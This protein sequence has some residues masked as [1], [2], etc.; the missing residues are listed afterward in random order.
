MKERLWCVTVYVQNKNKDFLLLHHKRLNQWV[1]P[2]GK[3][4]EGEIP[5]EAALRECLEETGLEIQLIGQSLPFVSSSSLVQ[6]LICPFGIQLNAVNEKR[7]HI[8]LVYT[9]FPLQGNL[10][11][12][13][14]EA[15]D[16]K[17]FSLQE[18]RELQTFESVIKWCEFF[19]VLQ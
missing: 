5:D 10:Q 14:N 17:W 2:G 19:H 15:Y 18:V 3:L 4:D 16:I 8:D 13:E 9:G 11:F 1:P 7:D 12:S 6:T